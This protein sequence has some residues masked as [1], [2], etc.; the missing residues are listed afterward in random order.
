MKTK[1]NAT[2]FIQALLVVGVM[3]LL[4]QV[5]DQVLQTKPLVPYVVV[6]LLGMLGLI[7]KSRFK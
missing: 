7:V 2:A 6:T 3:L 1:E 4:W 5:L